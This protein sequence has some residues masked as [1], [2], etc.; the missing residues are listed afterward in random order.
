MNWKM[1]SFDPYKTLALL[2]GI[3]LMLAFQPVMADR[4][5]QINDK[6][7]AKFEML[8]ESLSDLVDQA[9]LENPD[10]FTPSQRDHMRNAGKRAKRNRERVHEAGGFKLMGRK[11]KP[12][13]L[14]V[15]EPGDGIGDD[16]GFCTKGEVC[17][18][19]IGD[20]IGDEDGLCDWK[21][22]GKQEICIENC[23]EDAIEDLA[24]NYDAGAVADI[25]ESMEEMTTILDDTSMALQQR[26][27]RM[28][29][30]VQV[31]EDD[32]PLIEACD[33]LPVART[34]SYTYEQLKG[35]NIANQA[36]QGAYNACDSACNQDSF[37]WNCSAACTGLAIASAVVSG[38]AEAAELQDDTVTAE[39]VDAAAKCVQIVSE[40]VEGLEEKLDTIIELLNTPQG[41]R[42]DFPEK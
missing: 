42:P 2:T 14:V 40:G 10:M 16:D 12:E 22:C 28:T 37:G 15:E 5:D 25:E 34:R 39:T 11:S 1:A 17:Q 6:L 35:Y 18:E 23:D 33:F 4:P 30:D 8:N 41:K 38:I 7:N 20:G 36:A 19:V 24:D 13:C 9:I 21:F 32:P 29:L 27:Q 31:G 3:L 26:S